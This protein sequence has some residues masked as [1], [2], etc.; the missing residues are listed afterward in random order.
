MGDKY[1]KERKRGENVYFY[2]VG[3]SGT[4]GEGLVF[5]NK[6][7]T[8]TFPMSTLGELRTEFGEANVSVYN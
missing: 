1:R 2:P 6:Y 8:A 4:S 5:G 7:Q 3:L